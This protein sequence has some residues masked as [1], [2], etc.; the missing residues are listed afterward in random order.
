MDKLLDEIAPIKEIC[1]KN[2]T[3]DWFDEEIYQGIKARDKLF[4]T[5]KRS[6]LHTDN[7]KFKNARNRLQDLIKKKKQ[8]FIAKKLNDNIANSKELWKTH[9]S[10]GLPSKRESKSKI[11][12]NTNGTVPFDAKKNA[13]TF[14]T[15]FEGLATELVNRLPKTTNKYFIQIPIRI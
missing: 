6:R 12:L 3:E 10:L 5:F 15:Y 4:K 8:N 2:N 1:I 14:K 11:C 9:K 7:I 13:E